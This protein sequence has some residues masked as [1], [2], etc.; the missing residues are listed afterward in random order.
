MHLSDLL[1]TMI[2]AL[3]LWV[4]LATP[5]P[6]TEDGIAD[7]EEVRLMLRQ[8]GSE[9]KLFTYLESIKSPL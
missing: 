8:N 4:Q 5:P 3:D 1:L 7:T 9:I 6:R 2:Q